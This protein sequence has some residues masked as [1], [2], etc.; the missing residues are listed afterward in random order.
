MD[1][2][3]PGGRFAKAGRDRQLARHRKWS[4]KQ[5]ERGFSGA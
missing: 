3:S 5:A 2:K 1:I 4:M